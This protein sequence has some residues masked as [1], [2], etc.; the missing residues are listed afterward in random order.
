MCPSSYL[1]I[2]SRFAHQLLRVVIVIR[3]II[4]PARPVIANSKDGFAI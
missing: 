2:L 1:R 3:L 4:A